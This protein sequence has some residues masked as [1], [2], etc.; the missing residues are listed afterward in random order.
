MQGDILAIPLASLMERLSYRIKKFR[1]W[2]GQTTI[3]V[4][5]YYL[6]DIETMRFPTGL[7][8]DVCEVLD[9]HGVEYDFEDQREKPEW[10][11]LK[12]L[13]K[14][15]DDYQ[16]GYTEEALE[17]TRGIYDIPTGGGKTIMM[18]HLVATA[19]VKTLVMVPSLELLRQTS[20]D[21]K[22]FLGF[23]PGKIGGGKFEFDQLITVAT[24]QSLWSRR[25]TRDI[26]KF[27]ASIQMIIG[28][29]IHHENDTGQCSWYKLFRL[30]TNAYY[31][32]GF[33]G[34]PMMTEAGGIL[35]KAS[36]GNIIKGKIHTS[37]LIEK[38]YLAKP[39]V[40]MVKFQVDFQ[41]FRFDV[42]YF[43]GIIANKFRNRAIAEIA[44]D[45]ARQGKLV[46]IGVTR[47]VQ[48][49]MIQDMVG[50][51]GR[52]M[53]GDCSE[54]DR[55]EAIENFRSGK[56]KILIGTIYGEGSNFP[57]VNCYINA[58]GGKSKKV[59][60]QRVGRSLRVTKDKKEAEVI[61]F[62][63]MDPQR[64]K[65]DRV[66]GEVRKYDGPLTKHS[67]HRLKVYKEE[68]EFVVNMVEKW[69]DLVKSFDDKNVV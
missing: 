17:R 59:V 42:V 11:P 13:G 33:S 15:R 20:N 9:E 26:K 67:K 38:G 27:M 24:P 60:I 37:E 62:Y 31:R 69:E 53:Q 10:K 5:D 7:I 32:F 12:F 66:T 1:R 52:F 3:K 50:P 25:K 57:E 41:H 28:D 61:D 19:G 45:R 21:F 46:L 48:G 23:L 63:D 2:Y 14:L 16:V 47:V 51:F 40:Q 56:K 34:T 55:K 43:N 39:T 68:P 65:V 35:V 22:D 49:E 8:S 36:T 58:P 29:E 6:F 30:A 54:E 4:V 18:S 64:V 44:L